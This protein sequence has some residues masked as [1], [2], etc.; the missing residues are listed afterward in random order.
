VYNGTWEKEWKPTATQ[1]E[2]ADALC[3]GYCSE[4]DERADFCPFHTIITPCSAV[5]IIGIAIAAVVVVGVVIG[6]LVFC[7][8]IKKKDE[9]SS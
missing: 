3:D 7:F 4:L 5:A 8:V 9:G 6:V 2:L 1:Q